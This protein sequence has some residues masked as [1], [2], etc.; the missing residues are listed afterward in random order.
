MT[1]ID[2]ETGSLMGAILSS[3]LILVPS[4]TWNVEGAEE[5]FRGHWKIREE[6]RVNKGWSWTIAV[7]L[8][9]FLLTWWLRCV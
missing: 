4:I 6:I 5:G 8:T 1:P 9:I 2:K 3:A 7:T